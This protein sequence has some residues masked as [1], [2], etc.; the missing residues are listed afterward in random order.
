MSRRKAEIFNLSFLDLLTSALGAVIFLFIITPKGGAP[1]AEKQQLGVYID[2]VNHKVF[3]VLPDSLWR[4]AVGD[5]LF[6]V[7]VD[8]REMPEDKP[9]R[10][11]VMNE[12]PERMVEPKEPV[13]QPEIPKVSTRPAPQPEPV[14]TSPI[15]I[16]KPTPTKEPE[17]PTTKPSS[18]YKGSPPSVPCLVSFEISWPSAKDNVDLFV[19]RGNDCVYGGRKRD[20]DIGQWDS[21]KSRNRLFGNDLRTNQEAVRQFDA[22]IPGEYTLYAQFKESDVN[23]QSV[24][25][26]GLIYTK[27]KAGNEKG[28]HFSKTLR[29]SEERILLG[30]VTLLPNGSFK[31]K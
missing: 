5:T 24:T 17:K 3:G 15:P 9:E 12:A 29:L 1:A 8:Y 30:K 27:D 21:G 31:L 25:I 13:K 23:H 10:I 14:K 18:P 6:T 4:K 28:E 19:C 20:N 22:I 7:L 16:S 2:T 26:N 11:I